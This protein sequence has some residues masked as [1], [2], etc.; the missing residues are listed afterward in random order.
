MAAFKNP[1]KTVTP[2][3]RVSPGLST[4]WRHGFVPF[5]LLPIAHLYPVCNRVCF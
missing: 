1:R 5:A 4:V 3:P 2:R